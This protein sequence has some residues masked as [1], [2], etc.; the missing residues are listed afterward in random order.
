MRVS[1]WPWQQHLHLCLS[2]ADLQAKRNA[3]YWVLG[4]VL[5]GWGAVLPSG[6][7]CPSIV[8][9]VPAL[10]VL[11][12]AFTLPETQHHQEARLKS[13]CVCVRLLSRLSYI[14]LCVPV[15]YSLPRSSAQNTGVGCHA[16]LQ[17]V[18]P[19]QRSN[20]RLLWLLYCGGLFTAEPA[21]RPR[22]EATELFLWHLPKTFNLFFFKFFYM[23]LSYHLRAFIC[24]C[25]P[26]VYKVGQSR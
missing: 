14:R 26:S 20:S 2:R 24:F 6:D 15:A 11:L 1:V 3:L 21:G 23:Y 13:G 8:M 10:Q 9:R 16:F 4:I 5:S 18:F 22:G 7:L 25:S 17:D 12:T 19:A